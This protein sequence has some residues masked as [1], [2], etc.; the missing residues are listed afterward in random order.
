MDLLEKKAIDVIRNWPYFTER[1]CSLELTLEEH[2]YKLTNTLSLT[3][4]S[5]TNATFS[6]VESF[7]L[8]HI[9]YKERYERLI[10]ERDIYLSVFD[11]TDLSDIERDLIHFMAKGI[12]PLNY[13][14]MTKFE[15]LFKIYQVQYA[16][17]KKLA[18]RYSELTE[19]LNGADFAENY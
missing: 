7:T 16:A 11:S 8:Q 13:A 17:V 2:N 9:R 18:K 3:P 19:P 15:P 6:K 10:E 5:R 12:T 4:P 1:I 14:R